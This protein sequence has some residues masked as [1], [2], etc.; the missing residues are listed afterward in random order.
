MSY[1]RQWIEEC[2]RQSTAAIEFTRQ[3]FGDEQE[4][5]AI[6]EV[7]FFEGALRCLDSGIVPEKRRPEIGHELIEQMRE[8][9][10]ASASRARAAIA[11]LS[12]QDAP[13]K[14][15]EELED[16]VR[17]AALLRGYADSFQE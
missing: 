15:I 12:Q 17:D 13:P 2:V 8:R 3:Q 11:T 5:K 6:A 16:I 10:E 7:A 1:L 4:K 9:A 14:K